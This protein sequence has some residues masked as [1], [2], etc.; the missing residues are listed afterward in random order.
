MSWLMSMIS[1]FMYIMF[2]FYD[3]MISVCFIKFMLKVCI[4]LYIVNCTIL[5][6]IYVIVFINIIVILSSYSIVNGV[7]MVFFFCGDNVFPWLSKKSI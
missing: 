1:W 5:T 3:F 2:N 4:E 7:I 6:L